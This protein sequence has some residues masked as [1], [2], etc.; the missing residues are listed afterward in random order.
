VGKPTQK[1]FTSSIGTH[2][3]PKENGGLEIKDPILMNL[4]MGAKVVW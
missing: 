2:I 3:A 4:E 1:F